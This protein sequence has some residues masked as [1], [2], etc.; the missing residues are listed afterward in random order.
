MKI[1][2]MRSGPAAAFVA[3]S[4]LLAAA[5]VASAQ[6]ATPA[7]FVCNN[8]NLEGSVSVYTINPDGSLNFIEKVITGA[9]QSGEPTHPGNNAYSIS[10]TPSGRFLA[11]SHATA[12]TTEQ[13]TILEVGSDARVSI[14]ATATTPDSPLDLG[15]INDTTLAVTRTRTSGPNDVIV[16]RWDE[17]ARTLTEIDRDA[18]PGFTSNLLVSN[19][20]NHVF[21]PVSP[22][23]GGGSSIV[24]FAVQPDGTLV[25]SDFIFTDGAYPLGPGLSP[26]SRHLYAGSGTSSGGSRVTGMAFDDE[27]GALNL[28]F[29]S[30]YPSPGSSP[31]QCVV[32]PDGLWVFAGHGSD[33]TIR[34]FSRDVA[35]GSLTSTGNLYDV[36]SQSSLGDMKALRLGDLDLL[37]FTDKETFDGTP[38]GTFSAEI[39]PDGTLRII[40]ER[41]DGLGISPNDIAVWAGPQTPQCPADWDGSGGIDGDDITAFFADWQAGNADIDGSGGTDG[42]D[43]TFFFVR[44]QAGC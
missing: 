25:E 21:A 11:T 27:N 42:D 34:I 43:I 30:P 13:I 29:D 1:G 22:L 38:R 7:A 36:G 33:G 20:R 32:S 6:S 37:L 41:L 16:Y 5:G 39:M 19:S 24:T 9:R 35:T 23:G 17:A 44:W 18:T 12:L 2:P 4:T 8:G 26:D 15:W 10:I 31:K 40:T 14:Y 3:V 28:L